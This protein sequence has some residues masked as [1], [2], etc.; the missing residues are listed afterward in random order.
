LTDS[1]FKITKEVFRAN[2]GANVAQAIYYITPTT[3]DSDINNESEFG[4]DVCLDKL[5]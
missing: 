2:Q 5:L 3:L 1:G 4:N